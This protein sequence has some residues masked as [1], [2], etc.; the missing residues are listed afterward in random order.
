[1]QADHIAE[2]L[3]GGAI[4]QAPRFGELVVQ[5]Q[6]PFGRGQQKGPTVPQV[7]LAVLN[8][9]M[10]PPFVTDCKANPKLHMIQDPPSKRR[11]REEVQFVR[12]TVGD[13][14]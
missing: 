7:R 2:A 14:D 13:A 1:M 12:Y 10:N 8:P 3:V 9:E 5:M 11:P 4:H 6:T